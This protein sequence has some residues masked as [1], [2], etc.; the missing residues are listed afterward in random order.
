M[1]ALGQKRSFRRY[2]P[3]VRYAPIADTAKALDIVKT[4]YRWKAGEMNGKPA[5]TTLGVLAIW[6]LPL[7][8]KK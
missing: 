8:A 2:H 1:S 7:P 4:R 6:T 5:V 3:N